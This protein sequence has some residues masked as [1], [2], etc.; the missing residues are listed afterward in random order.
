[1]Q[2][3]SGLSRR[4]LVALSTLLSVGIAGCADGEQDDAGESD[5]G[6]AIDDEATTDDE[7]DEDDE[8]PPAEPEEIVPEGQGPLE[9]PADDEWTSEYVGYQNG[10]L[11][12]LVDGY[13]NRIPDYSWAGYRRSEAPI[14]DMETVKTIEPVAGDNVDHIEAAVQEVRAIIEEEDREHA[15][16]EL[17]PGEYRI[18]GPLS[19]HGSGV[20]VRGA[21]DG[22]DPA[23]NTILT[24]YGQEE[25]DPAPQTWLYPF[26]IEFGGRD[27]HGMPAAADSPEVEITTDLVRVGERTFDVADASAFEEGDHI[28]IYHPCTRAWLDAVDGGGTADDPEWDVDSQPIYYSRHITAIDGDEITIDA[29]VYNHLDR[30]LARSV[31]YRI[32]RSGL[33]REM[34]LEDLRIEMQ[35]TGDRQQHH[36]HRFQGVRFQ[37]LED[38][39]A[40][41]C[42][43][44]NFTLF[45][46]CA[47]GT[48]RLTIRDCRAVAPFSE[49][50]GGF[51]YNFSA[52]S[53]AQLI[54]Y[55]QCYAHRGRHSF[56]ANGQSTVSGFVAK[57]VVV[58]QPVSSCEPGHHRWTQGALYDR[59]ESIGGVPEGYSHRVHFGNR[60]SY[61]SGH[62]W[63]AVHS[64]AWNSD[65]HEESGGM[66]V[67]HPPTAQNYSIGSRGPVMS[68]GPFGKPQGH[69]EGHN[70]DGLWPDSL[71]LAQLR[72]RHARAELG[73]IP[74][75]L[76]TAADPSVRTR[77]VD[78]EFFPVD[79]TL[80]VVAL[81]TGDGEVEIE[82]HLENEHE[83]DYDGVE[84]RLILDGPGT[85][86]VTEPEAPTR[87]TDGLAPADTVSAS[88]TLD[89][90]APEESTSLD[91][92]IQAT[93]IVEES[94]QRSW[95]TATVR[96][97]PADPEPATFETDFGDETVD[98]PPTDW[99]PLLGR[100]EDA[101]LVTAD[102][103]AMGDQ[104]ITVSEAAGSAFQPIA[105][106]VLPEPVRNVEVLTR[107]KVPAT[108][109]AEHASA[110]VYVRSDFTAE[111]PAG[112]YAE[113]DPVTNDGDG[114]FGVF[115]APE[116]EP[117]RSE[118]GVT[119]DT[120]YW[121]RFQFDENE[122]QLR[123]WESGEAEP[124]SWD[125]GWPA[126]NF[127]T[128]SIA[129]GAYSLPPGT[130][131]RFDVIAVGV[132][133][134][135]P[136]VPE[137]D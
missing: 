132:A 135:S 20:V 115:T 84:L 29:P 12:Y 75:D 100:H 36:N 93:T 77:E 71:F 19:I 111:D 13:H 114:E 87:S 11:T 108:G 37:G 103:E 82:A 54:L 2:L 27:R 56:T 86:L 9:G 3:E 21:G 50:T 39:W 106:D 5:A 28:A 112:Y 137:E 41:G 47:E 125:L 98:E 131:P 118:S 97:I 31:I 25:S 45:G 113:L 105:W 14:P 79:P 51:R 85:E 34:G 23:E 6:D 70:E 96:M 22:T 33:H 8:E 30:D 81:H 74:D 136:A 40:R 92:T 94:Y 122:F 80:S 126:G 52:Q 7:P 66:L 99:T 49:I 130:W 48:D 62:G 26:A 61:G 102:A 133:G 17:A 60:G 73:D 76:L 121:L 89:V 67:E 10:W 110:R 44:T 95:D 55:E 107:V 88:W 129:L 120:W 119:G 123:R 124:D 128:G 69:I 109:D 43:V 90:I 38:G 104:S 68:T 57:D 101:W 53:N 134:E 58:D 35:A 46:F 83:R 116:D 24:A 63:S 91:V 78:T 18:A 64:V 16:L 117:V 59:Y 15:A 127:H 72:A 1:M 32:D 4:Q 65:V 42:T